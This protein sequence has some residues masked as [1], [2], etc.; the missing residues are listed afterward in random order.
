[1]PAFTTHFL[2]HQNT[3]WLAAAS[4][5]ARDQ[6]VE[7]KATDTWPQPA[8]APASDPSPGAGGQA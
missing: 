6:R 8:A 4:A 7:P 3:P 5:Q 2:G 1:M